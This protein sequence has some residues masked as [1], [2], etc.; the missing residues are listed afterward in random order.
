MRELEHFIE[1]YRNEW[2]LFWGIITCLI[3]S[4]LLLLST[5]P[6]FFH[7][8]IVG[9]LFA[10]VLSYILVEIVRK[11]GENKSRP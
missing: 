8:G 4:F 10:A 3:N 11:K 9:L 6:L 1:K 2:L 7:A 5:N